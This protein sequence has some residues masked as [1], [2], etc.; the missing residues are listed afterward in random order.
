MTYVIT[1]PCCNDA[2][3]VDVC[4]VNCIHPT[5][6]E[7]Q[8]ATTEMLY[9]DPDTCIDC[10]AC[11]EECPVEAIVPDND[12]VLDDEPYL[13][14][15]RDWFVAHPTGPDWPEPVT[16]P[17]VP[18]D[19]DV[20]RVA[21]VGSGPA[22]CY[23]TMG[24]T[25]TSRVE[26]DVFD[27]LPTPYGLV[28]SGVAPDHPGT[29]G[30]TEQFRAAVGKRSVRC[31]FNVEVGRDVTHEELLSHHHAVLYAVGAAGDRALGVPGEELPGS[32]AA[33][34]FVAWYNGHPDYADRTFDL[35]SERVVIVGNGN[36]ALD[37]ARILVSDPEEL[38]KTDLAD[39][40]LEALRRSNVREVVVLGR[41]GPAQ[42]AFTNP[43]L[44]ALTQMAGVDVVVESDEAELDPASRALLDSGDTEPSVRLKVAQIAGL[45][46]RTPDPS[47]RRIVLRFLVSPVEVL[48]D[49]G[50]EG[51]RVVRNAL[52]ADA[53]GRL[54]AEP[55]EQTSTIETGLVLRSVGYRGTPV[56]DV[57][58]DGARGVIPNENGRV[59]DPETGRPLPGVYVAGWIKRG[60]TGVIG[61]NRYCSAETVSMLVDD[62]VAGRL[63]DPAERDAFETLLAERAPEAID[64]RGWQSIDRVERDEGKATGRPRRKLVR[65][66]DMLAAAHRE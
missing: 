50:V 27:R 12:L 52:V 10:G 29:K 61:T 56:P 14:I 51:V 46:A 31:H 9:I 20:L 33:T 53:T 65:I 17:A 63:H 19:R 43:E 7:P 41:R 3:C 58:F 44:L 2:S 64:Y 39:H 59:I 15:N 34:E 1:Q 55:S 26:V 60:P 28:R 6:D 62:Y 38:A 47:R 66:E 37:V 4:P 22:A 45:A 30:V 48:G 49:T 35:S 23:A 18:K 57:P 40:A 25:S 32:H 8:F 24:L 36:V 21:V 42:A 11:V 13:D 54:V 16:T 5:P